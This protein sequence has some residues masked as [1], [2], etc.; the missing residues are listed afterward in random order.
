[1][2]RYYIKYNYELHNIDNNHETLRRLR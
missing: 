2:Q 1:M